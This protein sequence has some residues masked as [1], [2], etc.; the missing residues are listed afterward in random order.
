[1]GGLAATSLSFTGTAHAATNPIRLE[2]YDVS[3]ECPTQ[4]EAEARL[5]A[6][7]GDPP[8]EARPAFSLVVRGGRGEPFVGTL[9]TTEL[10]GVRSRRELNDATCE[11]IVWSL[12]FVAAL[13]ISPDARP[14]PASTTPPPSPNGEA[15]RSTAAD[16][17]R[18]RPQLPERPRD[19]P[20]TPKAVS[21]GVEAGPVVRVGPL[22]TVAYGAEIR[23]AMGAAGLAVG[24]ATG[25]EQSASVGS[26]NFWLV[27]GRPHV[28]PLRIGNALRVEGCAGVDVGALLASSRGLPGARSVA[29]LWVAGEIGARLGIELAAPFQLALDARAGV[30]FHRPTY[31]TDPSATTLYQV[32]LV[33]GALDIFAGLSWK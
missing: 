4:R 3:A 19:E 24:F 8:L 26:A 32:P 14:L 15:D 21:H 23:A 22:P 12:V 27:T 30:P 5:E 25:P 10:S 20:P 7:L 9:E 17:P 13:A 16:A 11:Q 1:M 33:V 31:T 2:H 29:A 18:A 28:C 6:H